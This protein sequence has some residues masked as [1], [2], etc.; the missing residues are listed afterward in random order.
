M[1]RRADTVKQ[2][3]GKV[4]LI[5]D[6]SGFSSKDLE[7]YRVLSEK[8]CVAAAVERYGRDIIMLVYLAGV[9]HGAETQLRKGRPLATPESP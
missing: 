9:Y 5:P 2:T 6:L 8:I 1:S 7:P 4:A 3:D